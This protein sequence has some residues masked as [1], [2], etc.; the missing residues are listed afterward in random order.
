MINRQDSRDLEQQILLISE[1]TDPVTVNLSTDEKVIARITDG[2][3]RQPASALRELISN[4]YDADASKITIETDYPRF[5]RITIRDNGIGM[6]ALTLANMIKH[7]GGSAKRE[8]FGIDLGI[9]DKQD[10][11]KTK[12]GRRII[13]KIGIGLFSVAQLTQQFQIIT[14]VKG[15]NYRLIADVALRTFSEGSQESSGID[16]VKKDDDKFKSGTVT[17]NKILATDV[18]S[19]GTDIILYNLRRN[20]LSILRSQD[21]W[22]REGDSVKM[23]SY[24]IGHYI[25]DNNYFKEVKP[26]NLPWGEKDPVDK[27][28]S[29]IYSSLLKEFDVTISTPSLENTFDNYFWTLWSLALSSPIKY[30]DKHP[31][32]L[33]SSDEPISFLISNVPGGQV[34]NFQREDPAQTY[35]SYENTFY[36]S[37]DPMGGFDV[38]VDGIKLYRPVSFNN[39]KKTNN[40]LKTPLMFYGKYKADFSG[41]DISTTGG[42]LEFEA[43][44]YWNSKILPSEHNGISIRVN[45]ASGTSYDSRWLG[46]S[47]AEKTTLGQITAEI[48]VLNGL[49]AAL[50]IDRESF[51]YSHPHYQIVSKWT[52]NALRQITKKQKDLRRDR[53]KD[54]QLYVVLNE[55]NEMHNLPAVQKLQA[56]VDC[57]PELSTDSHHVSNLRESGLSAFLLKNEKYDKA[58]EIQKEKFKLIFSILESNDLLSGLSYAQQEEI[59]N[60]IAEV[61]FGI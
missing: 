26:M 47:V 57:F 13:G 53:N 49:D 36:P 46:Y 40:A 25:L 56:R 32:E 48:F 41:K 3:Y 19:H 2:I 59:L 28:F 38:Y 27:R 10:C 12:S 23:P 18:D 17:I 52:H 55:L 24:H 15:T 20:A 31:F 35:K 39:Q 9:T 61:F 16:L 51:N 21:L 44:F 43:Y 50:N 30:I 11:T 58:S 45:D 34:S 22:D 33:T 4:A 14:K 37:D 8:E 1:G 29:K 42:E 5:E 6:S 54:K 60:D 7:I